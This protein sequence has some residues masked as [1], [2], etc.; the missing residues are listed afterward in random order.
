MAAIFCVPFAWMLV[1][2]TLDLGQLQ[3][4]A[5]PGLGLRR[6]PARRI[7]WQPPSDAT[8]ATIRLS[9]LLQWLPL[10]GAGLAIVALR[11]LD[12]RS[13]LRRVLPAAA[14]VAVAVAIL[15]ADLFRANM[16]YNTGDPGRQR[17]AARPR[18]PSATCSRA[19]RTASPGLTR[20]ANI[21]PLQ[22]DLAMRYGLYD[23][24]GYDYPVGRALRHVVAGDRRAAR[25]LQH[26]DVPR[27]WPRPR[28]L[29]GMS[30][31]SV[32]DIIQDPTDP[33]SRL[34]GLEL[35]YSGRDAR[36]Y[37]NRNALPRA[38]L[39]DRQQVVRRRRRGAERDARPRASTPA[40]WRSP[41]SRSAGIPR[42]DGGRQATAG[43]GAAGT[44]RPR[45]G[46]RPRHGPQRRSLLVLTDVALPGL[47]GDRRRPAGRHR[48]RGLPAAR[49]GGPRRARHD[50][51]FSYEP[52]SWRLGW[53]ISAL[54]LAGAGRC[55]RGGLAAAPRR[56]G[57][58]S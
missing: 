43:S 38:F 14:F 21:Q 12:T 5:R 9:A 52:A 2:G 37:R 1:A 31:L 25:V 13:R 27:R 4:G 56:R 57:S 17:R 20:S 29:R 41:R 19:A 50:V 32:A 10:A 51:E 28:A 54:G 53:I 47:E 39:V 15:V 35:A 26:P 16:G 34:P 6:P 58:S 46:G 23:A 44:L 7:R 18:A 42:A 8:V 55:G 49:S 30:L 33:P 3:A 24:R 45:A 48:A 36:V 22:P 40:A 11:L